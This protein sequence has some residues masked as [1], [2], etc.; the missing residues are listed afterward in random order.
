MP[1]TQDALNVLG[2]PLK[3]CSH[4][5]LTGFYRSGCCETSTD[6]VGMHTV[7]AR[8]TEPFLAYS[9]AQGND[10]VTPRPEFGFPGLKPGDHWCLCAGR[11][12]ESLEAGYAPPVILAATHEETLAVIDLETLKHHALDGDGGLGQTS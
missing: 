12:R 3:P 7:C 10:L 11:W 9:A 8:V 1:T 4:D 5:P 6:D 2:T